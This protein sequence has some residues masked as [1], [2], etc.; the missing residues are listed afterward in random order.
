MDETDLDKAHQRLLGEIEA[1]ARDT[2]FWTDRARF[3]D[4]VMAAMA[5]VPRHEFVVPDDVPYAYI[6]RP[7]CIGHGQTI[8]QPY[9]VAVMTDLLDL[10]PGDR[11][12]EIGAGSGYQSAVLAEIVGRVFTVEVV[13]EL[14][15]AARERLRRLGYDNVEVL[16]GDGY[17][18]WPENEPFDAIMVT[19]AP[20]EIPETLT[21]QLKPGGRMVIPIGRAHETQTLF[22]CVKD[23]DG[24]VKTARTLPVAFVPMVHKSKER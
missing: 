24:T 10:E 1:E 15:D 23:E 3:S 17:R 11:V 18:G 7:R 2:R 8:S 16:T 22:V 4:R 6:N 5:K 20:T 14:A 13:A 9:M 12:L 19:A 21:D